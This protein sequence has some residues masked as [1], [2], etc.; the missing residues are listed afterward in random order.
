VAGFGGAGFVGTAGFAVR[1]AGV[2]GCSGLGAASGGVA[3]LAAATGFGV[4]CVVVRRGTAG[5]LLGAGWVAGAVATLG[6]A[7]ALEAG[8]AAG[9]GAAA[10]GGVGFCNVI[11]GAGAGE[12]AGAA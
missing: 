1:G 2:T 6:G 5:L 8:F 9:F 4:S 12:G 7:D 3:G 11:R 10:R